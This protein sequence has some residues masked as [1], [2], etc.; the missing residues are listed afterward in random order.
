MGKRKL[1]A[2]LISV[3]LMLTMVLTACGGGSG[4]A[5]PV[6]PVPAS[7][8]SGAGSSGAS[9]AASSTL[10]AA[11]LVNHEIYTHLND[12][13]LT[14]V[15][16]PILND[17]ASINKALP[18][19]QK[20]NVVVGWSEPAMT[21][22]W[23]AGIQQGAKKYAAQYGYTLKFYVAG[24]F[25]AQQQSADIENMLTAG[26]DVL[27][28]DAVDVQAC[29]V[30]IQKCIAKG[31]PVISM[32]PMPENDSVVTAITLNY[33][34]ASY[35]AGYYAAQQFTTPIESVF[36][37]GQ[38]GHPISDA[39]LCGFLGGWC[40]GKE[41]QA[42]T[43]KP[44]REDAMLSG[45]NAYLDLVKNGKV[46]LT[47]DFGLKVDG[48]AAGNF[49]DVGGQSAAENLLTAFPNV[50]MIFPDNDQEGAGAIRVL[51]QRGLTDK[52]KV[53]TGCDGDT[54]ALTLVKDGKLGSTGYNNPEAATEG[55]F[56]LIHMM[57][58]ENYDANNMPA[59]TPLYQ[60]LL[61]KANYQQVYD[62]STT[63]GKLIPVEF[64]TI[65]QL[66]QEAQ[67]NGGKAPAAPGA[68]GS[69]AV[70]AAGG[71]AASQ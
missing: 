15:T 2:A 45:Y 8:A 46:D 18:V 52:I 28:L 6:T 69:S 34:E 56:R 61:T 9:G 36:I 30:D 37:P 50:S 23:F 57:F 17:R 53:F 68:S 13:A 10:N 32:Y 12:D 65:P 4:G 43:A 27:V 55:A 42:G 49:D 11:Q 5:S 1:A 70:P 47:K 71:S 24:T 51:D 67:A 26:I 40:Y 66:N 29:Q 38:V 33:Y 44:Y 60:Q 41:V 20:K 19:K 48:M 16:L 63:Y 62:P 25:D 54:S 3:G 31:V 21:S 7:G 64:K 59:I 58:E 22:A 14:G 39:R 35:N